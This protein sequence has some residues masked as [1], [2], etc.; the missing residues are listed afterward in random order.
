MPP[1]TVPWDEI[2]LVVFDVDGTLYDQRGLRRQMLVRLA[3]AALRP[4]GV[5]ILRVLGFYRR[6][7]EVMGDQGVEDFE[8]RLVTATAAHSGAS[9]AQV[10]AIVEEWIETRPLPLLKAHRY[11]GLPALFSGLR[12]NGK[13]IGILSDY[14]AHA[15]LRALELSADHVVSAGDRDVSILKPD[16]RGLNHLMARAGVR[17]ERTVM[18]GDRVERDGE[19]ARRAGVRAAI[20]SSVAIDGWQT[21]TSYEGE[22]FAAMTG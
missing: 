6:H 20:R 21:F 10:R 3:G 16:P 17:A 19:A 14:P 22:D 2:D 15:K 13:T 11:A 5:K 1:M 4:G 18:I 7:R 12:R 9:E 8:D